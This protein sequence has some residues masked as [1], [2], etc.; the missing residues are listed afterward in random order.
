M[1]ERREMYETH[2]RRMWPERHDADVRGSLRTLTRMLRR[3]K[4]EEAEVWAGRVDSETLAAALS[5]PSDSATRRA[6][7]KEWTSRDRIEGA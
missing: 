4:K 2:F 1:T 7:A 3:A 6:A 5:M